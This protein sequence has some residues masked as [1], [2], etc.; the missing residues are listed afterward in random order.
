VN[1][2]MGEHDAAAPRAYPQIH[3]ATAPL[4]AAARGTGDTDGINLWA[5]RNYRLAK[6]EPAGELV[7]RWGAEARRAF[8]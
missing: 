3:Y 7:M 6:A 2:F 8:L 4:R 1:R 5:G